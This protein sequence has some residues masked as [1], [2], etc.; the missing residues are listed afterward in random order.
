MGT[1]SRIPTS[2]LVMPLVAA[3]PFGLAVRDTIHQRAADERGAQLAMHEQLQRA[4]DQAATAGRRA[5]FAALHDLY[6]ARPASRGPAAREDAIV[7]GHRGE[8]V[9]EELDTQ[10]RAGWGQP[11]RPATWLDATAH[12]RAT[13]EVADCT[14]RFSS[15]T[16]LAEWIPDTG[17]PAWLG[18]IGVPARSIQGEL[19]GDTLVWHAPA[20]DCV[21]CA[22]APITFTARVIRGRI[23]SVR[24]AITATAPEFIDIETR[25]QH[26]LGELPADT[27]YTV[28]DGPP[29]VELENVGPTLLITVGAKPPR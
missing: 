1:A 25:L 6:G 29:R 9:C 22:D 12:T 11:A 13:F 27:F 17:A 7:V 14:L 19:T 28:W 10:L 2:L 4:A 5:R 8:D 18:L 23:A 20:L 26:A 21:A 15:Y 24:I 3:I 16:P